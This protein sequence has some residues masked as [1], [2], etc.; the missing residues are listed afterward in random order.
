M[1]SGKHG[2]TTASVD[3]GGFPAA[4]FD[5]DMRLFVET[6][7]QPAHPVS[8]QHRHERVGT[9]VELGRRSPFGKWGI[10]YSAMD[11]RETNTCRDERRGAGSI[12]PTLALLIVAGICCLPLRA[13]NRTSALVTR[14]Q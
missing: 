9:V 4:V 3:G 5:Q 6:E 8:R 10:A 14:L 1:A 2:T 7:E 12:E 13:A 11:V